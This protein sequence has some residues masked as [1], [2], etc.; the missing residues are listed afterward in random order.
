MAE[1][2]GRKRLK[3]EG[4]GLSGEEVDA[5]SFLA[6]QKPEEFEEFA[7]VLAKRG[8]KAAWMTERA[9]RGHIFEGDALAGALS[10][11][12]RERVAA[13]K[14]IK[15]LKKKPPE[16]SEGSPTIT[17][18]EARAVKYLGRA[19][20]EA[21]GELKGL[22]SQRN[23]SDGWVADKVLNDNRTGEFTLHSYRHFI[24][25]R[26]SQLEAYELLESLEAKRAW[27]LEVAP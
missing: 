19:E 17:F 9:R 18:A 7:G 3:L 10:E 5:V 4:R 14:L 12:W 6:R 11:E 20:P 16:P 2:A 23:P 25:E 1:S 22:L 13:F 27:A 21:A 26:E 24:N 8:K 15:D